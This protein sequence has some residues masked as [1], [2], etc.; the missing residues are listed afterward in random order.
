MEIIR[1]GY[2]WSLGGVRIF[3][4]D[5]G[6]EASQIIA[7]LQPLDGGTVNQVFGYESP[8]RKLTCYIV[9]DTDMHAILTMTT[10]GT[11]VALLSPEGDL[12]DFLV[13]KVNMPRQ[14]TVDQSLRPDLDCDA[15]VYLGEISLFED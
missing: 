15:P 10:T 7:R 4:I 9:G 11:A 3:V 6:E 5:S 14:K 8:S 1:G 13:Q 12:G 2:M